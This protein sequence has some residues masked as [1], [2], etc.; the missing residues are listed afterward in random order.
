V[1]QGA[2]GKFGVRPQVALQANTYTA[3]IVTSACGAQ[4]A[5]LA[6]ARVPVHMVRVETFVWE[7]TN[8]GELILSRDQC[9]VTARGHG[10]RES[11]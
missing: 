2:L 8:G 7:H 6:S 4:L 3:L 10:R 11:G 1:R 9:P 5:P